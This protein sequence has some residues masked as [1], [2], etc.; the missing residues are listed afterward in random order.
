MAGEEGA[1]PTKRKGKG[2]ANVLASLPST[3]PN[4]LGRHAAKR[5]AAA[6]P[7]PSAKPRA[8][9]KAKA[10]KKP[11]PV[12]AASVAKAAPARPKPVRPA[13]AKLDGPARKSAAKREP[14]REESAPSGTE[15]VT[16]VVQAAGELASVGLSIGGQ[17]VKRAVERLPKP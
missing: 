12:V 5:P 13:T 11:A 14:V 9:A 17:I 8:K 6:A 2:E 1:K 3:R 16:T 4:R 10:A 7:K 15:L